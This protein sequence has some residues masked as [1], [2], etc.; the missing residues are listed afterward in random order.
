M[1]TTFYR[2]IDSYPEAA[3]RNAIVTVGTFDGIH[4]GHQEILRRVQSE[5]AK[6]KVKP[7]LITFHPH[8]RTLVT[9]DNIP[10]LLTTIEEKERF[11]PH[12]FDGRVL[13]LDF[14]DKL[15]NLTPEEFVKNILIDRIGLKKLIVGYDH[16]L[17]K[18]R[19][20]GIEELRKLADKYNFQLEVV[21]PVLNGEKPISS[22]RIRNAILE[23]RYREAIHFLGHDYA[24]FGTVEKGIGLGRKLGYPTANIRYN[25]RKLLPVEGVYSC[26]LQ[27]GKEEKN[28]MMFIGRNH[29][30][31][32]DKITVEANIFDFDRDIYD[33]DIVAYPTHFIRNNKKFESTDDLIKQLET[34]KKR[35]L[36]TIEQEN[37]N[38][39]HKGTKGKNH[40][41]KSV[42]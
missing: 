23:N 13:I 10:M 14:N 5:G 18:N 17:G 1:N 28:G 22:S 41:G 34:D 2:G 24:I 21:Q 19:S 12:F 4:R 42:A 33:E 35:V 39:L 36:S 37:K 25:P 8:P 29:F 16:G 11:I 27:I 20:G 3:T 30:N 9:P 26:W 15:K 7:V 38:V 31:P 32:E 6:N 40:C